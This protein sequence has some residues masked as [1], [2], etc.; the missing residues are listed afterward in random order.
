MGKKYIATVERDCEVSLP[1][2]PRNKYKAEIIST[3]EL[4]P[5]ST[6]ITD[7]SEAKRIINAW[8]MDKIAYDLSFQMRHRW[9]KNISKPLTG[10][11][12]N[13]LEKKGWCA[14]GYGEAVIVK[15]D[16]TSQRNYLREYLQDEDEYM[17]GCWNE[18][19]YDA[20]SPV[21]ASLHKNES[22]ESLGLLI[23]EKFFEEFMDYIFENF[24]Y[25][26]CIRQ[27]YSFEYNE[28]DLFLIDVDDWEQI[29]E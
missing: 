29:K 4:P 16:E 19:I 25:T 5:P 21:L 14:V 3:E 7:S 6:S 18:E 26:D 1:F 11:D 2:K 10:R 20:V 12:I 8:D 28:Y 23:K 17:L 22:Y 13:E 15:K 9:G 27:E 24:D